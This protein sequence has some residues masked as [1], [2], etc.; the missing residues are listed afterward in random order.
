MGYKLK[1]KFGNTVEEW[2]ESCKAWINI[3]G[4]YEYRIIRRVD[5]IEWGM[6]FM[7]PHK[8]TIHSRHEDL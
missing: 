2:K 4:H 3:G 8:T 7:K 1:D 6:C 5:T